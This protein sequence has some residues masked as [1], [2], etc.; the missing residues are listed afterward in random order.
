MKKLKNKEEKRKVLYR[1]V[2][3]TIFWR[4]LQCLIDPD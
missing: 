3:G 4:R 2:V 1:S